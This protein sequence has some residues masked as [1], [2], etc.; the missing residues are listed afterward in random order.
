M[1]SP[2]DW[3]QR[4]L[5]NAAHVPSANTMKLPATTSNPIGAVSIL[6]ASQSIGRASRTML[7]TITTTTDFQLPVKN[8]TNAKAASTSAPVPQVRKQRERG[9]GMRQKERV[10]KSSQILMKTRKL[11][12]SL[13]SS[14]RRLLRITTNAKA[15]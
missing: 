9:I 2:V 1:V 14:Q 13:A 11:R 4:D 8:L 5:V 10:A 15:I 12:T 3:F 6:A 7:D